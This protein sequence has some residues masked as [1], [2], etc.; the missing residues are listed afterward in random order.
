[1]KQI[2]I[3]TGIVTKTDIVAKIRRFSGLAVMSE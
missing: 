2:L 3:G 1:M